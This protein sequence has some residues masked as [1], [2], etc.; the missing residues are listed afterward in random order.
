MG[1][2]V[3]TTEALIEALRTDA[4]DEASVHDMGGSI[5]PMLVDGRRRPG[6]RLRR[7]RRARRD[8]PRP[9]LLARRRDAGRLLRRAHG[10]GVGASGLQ[11]LQ[12]AVADPHLHRRSCRRRS[13]SRAAL[14]QE[15]IVGRRRRSSPAPRSGTRSSSP[16]VT[17]LQGAYVEG[18]VLL[19]G[20]R[21]GPGAVVRQAILDKNVD[22]PGRRAH[23]RRPRAGPAALPRQRRRRRRARQGRARAAVTSGA[24]RF[25]RGE[26]IAAAVTMWSPS[27]AALSDRGLGFRASAPEE[28]L[29]KLRRVYVAAAVALALAAAGCANNEDSDS[30]A[31]QPSASGTARVQPGRGAEGR[32]AGR[33]GADS[34]ITSPTASWSSAPTRRTSRTSSRTAAARSSAST[35]TSATRSPRSSA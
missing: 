10:P 19:P 26:P 15:S 7:Q 13:S 29:V 30:A 21:I 9:R 24:R 34:K 32:R 8:R 22:R 12:P 18:S 3:F 17:V 33:A 5:I 2:Y 4:G 23:R 16:D 27:A 35:S 6:L 28:A 25:R 14:A 31:A 20:V 1:N 11:P